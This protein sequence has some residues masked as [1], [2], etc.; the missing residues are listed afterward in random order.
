[1]STKLPLFHQLFENLSRKE[2]I[3]AFDPTFISKSGRRTYG[4]AKY[5]SGTAQQVKK[6][7]EAGCLAVVDVKDAT[8]YSM[9]VV[10]TPVA[11]EAESLMNHYIRLITQRLADIMKYTTILAVDGYFMKEGF[12]K[13]VT[14]S[15]LKV[16]TKAR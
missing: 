4:L 7:L 12:I 14:A 13:A 16:I 6:G 8:A 5:W 2:C 10:Q 11:Q 3:A 1:M 15:G 9:E